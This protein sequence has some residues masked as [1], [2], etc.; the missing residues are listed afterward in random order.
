MFKSKYFEW[1]GIAASIILVAF[2]IAAIV[3]GVNGRSTVQ[4]SLKQEAIVG[5]PDMTP[6]AIKAEAK[7]A[8]IPASIKLP[9]ESVAGKTID[10]GG[11]ARAFAKYMR[12][13]TLEA[14]KGYTYAQMGRYIAK[15]GTPSSELAAGGGTN[16]DKFALIDPATKRPVAN[17]ARDIWVTETAL[18]TA[19]N[20]S[21]MAEQLANF[22]IVVGV[23]L[24]L[25]GIGFGVLTLG[26]ALRRQRE[27]AAEPAQARTV[28]PAS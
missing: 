1:G 4:S 8:G 12:I 15:D 3:L 25:S 28:V 16:N 11:E 2:G 19:L 5:S 13:H 26:G 17:G 24:L 21:Y 9:T 20:T 27:V 7:Q 14:T 18:T 22:G 6:S 10:T 23:A